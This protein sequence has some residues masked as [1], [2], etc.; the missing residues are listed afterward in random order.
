M[1]RTGIWFRQHRQAAGEG[2]RTLLLGRASYL[3]TL[4]LGI[5]LAF[6]TGLQWLTIQGQTTQWQPAPGLILTIEPDLATDQHAAL[7]EQLRALET[8][9]SADYRSPEQAWAEF[10]ERHGL[11]K[12]PGLDKPP[13]PATILLRIDPNHRQPKTIAGLQQEL[14]KIAG[15]AEVQQDLVWLQ[16]LASLGQ[17]GSRLLD[18]VSLLLGLAFVL[19]V[20]Q[21]IAYRILRQKEVIRISKLVGGSDA[22]LRRPFLYLGFWQGFLGG[23]SSWLLLLLALFWVNPPWLALQQLY[24]VTPEP[25]TL[26]LNSLPPLLGIS[27]LLGWLGATLSARSRISAI[28]P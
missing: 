20:R 23:L 10:R 13:L 4:L 11:P 18:L 8:V 3:L 5:L 25:L 7:V 14:T 9:A 16:R 12:M 22:T 1:S 15:I 21:Q 27:T 28:K 2:L 19:L 26:S 17:L 24:S 6:P